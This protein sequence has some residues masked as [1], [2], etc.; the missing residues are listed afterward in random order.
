MRVSTVIS[1]SK[2]QIN[3]YWRLLTLLVTMTSTRKLFVTDDEM[4]SLNSRFIHYFT[5]YTTANYR[6]DQFY[7][8]IMTSLTQ[9]P[10]AA[11]QPQTVFSTIYNLGRVAPTL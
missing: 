8:L 9:R 4:I 3:F 1:T 7:S 5:C 6:I 2:V 11:I 10:D